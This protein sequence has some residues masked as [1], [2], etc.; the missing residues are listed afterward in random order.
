MARIIIEVGTKENYTRQVSAET[1][2][3]AARGYVHTGTLSIS[4]SAG[5]LRRLAAELNA[6]AD[7][8]DR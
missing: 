8:L 7:E 3:L 6:M 5:A 4:G 1:Q 2:L